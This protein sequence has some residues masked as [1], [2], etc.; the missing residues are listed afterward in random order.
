MKILKRQWLEE[1]KDWIKKT[2]VEEDEM[3][4]KAK[5]AKKKKKEK[6]KR[7]DANDMVQ[8]RYL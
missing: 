6:K 5:I 3:L 7:K 8:K 2:M 1:M 4:N